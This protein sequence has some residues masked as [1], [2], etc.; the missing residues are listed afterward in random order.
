PQP[1]SAAAETPTTTNPHAR[2]TRRKGRPT[3]PVVTKDSLRFCN[4]HRRPYPQRDHTAARYVQC[5]GFPGRCLS[6]PRQQRPQIRGQPR[7][8]GREPGRGGR[9]CA[10]DVLTENVCAPAAAAGATARAATDFVVVRL[11]ALA[12]PVNSRKLAIPLPTILLAF[13]P[14]RTT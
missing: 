4:R 10:F 3:R 8:R 12:G 7:K 11:V 1:A 5:T 6:P 13:G 14:D 9:G 2:A